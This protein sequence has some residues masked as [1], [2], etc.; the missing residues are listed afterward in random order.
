ML[1]LLGYLP[2]RAS[3]LL[4]IKDLTWVR[5]V[6]ADGRNR[7][8]AVRK[9]IRTG[10]SKPHPPSRQRHGLRRARAAFPLG[11]PFVGPAHASH[12]IFAVIGS[13]D[14]E[15]K[16]TIS[17]PFSRKEAAGGGADRHTRGACAPRKR[18][19]TPGEIVPL[20]IFNDLQSF[21]GVSLDSSAPSASLREP[22]E[23]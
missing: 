14:Q 5:G 15:P 2:V 16:N 8:K 7:Q 22:G 11:N 23:K 21:K 20:L 18:R 9:A 19:I 13:N 1:P 3:T 6:R 4:S 10:Y 17:Q 12:E